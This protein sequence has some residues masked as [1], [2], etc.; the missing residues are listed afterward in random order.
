MATQMYQCAHCDDAFDVVTVPS[1]CPLCHKPCC[2]QCEK[3]CPG[4]LSGTP[5]HIDENAPTTKFENRR[6]AG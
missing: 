3:T 1:R 6:T 5:T 2:G 4:V